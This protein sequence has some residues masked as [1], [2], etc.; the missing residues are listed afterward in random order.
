MNALD[1]AASTLGTQQIIDA[2]LHI[3]QTLDTIDRV[4]EQARTLRQVRASLYGA[5]EALFPHVE[6]V[7]EAWSMNV[8]DKRTYTEALLDAVRQ[9]A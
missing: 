9:T 4:S 6:S 8:E 2:I 1:T 3:D 5:L 7:L